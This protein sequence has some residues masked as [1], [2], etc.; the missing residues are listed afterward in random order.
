MVV[1]RRSHLFDISN[2]NKFEALRTDAKV[3]LTFATVASEA[4]DEGSEKRTR[5]RANARKAYDTVL[6]LSKKTRLGEADRQ[7]LA[8]GLGRLKRVLEALGES[9]P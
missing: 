6:R 3:G 7:Q 8:E 1:T 9:F 2:R 4:A 5:N